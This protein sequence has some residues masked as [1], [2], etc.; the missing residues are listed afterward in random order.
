[1]VKK[2]TL[3]VITF[4]LMNIF[5]VSFISAPFGYNNREFVDFTINTFT[6]NLT[7]LSELQDVDVTGVNNNDVLT[8]DS[9]SGLWEDQP[10]SAVGDTNE[11]TR[12]NALILTNC[13][14]TDKVIGVQSNGTVSCDTDLNTGGGVLSGDDVYLYNDSTTMSFNTTLA[15]TNLSVNS[16]NF[17]DNYNTT[18]TT[19]LEN[20]GG[21]L[22]IIDS[23]IE[24]LVISVLGNFF[25]QDL[26]ESSSVKFNDVNATGLYYG[27]GSQ[28]TG[29]TLT[30]TDPQWT[31]NQSLY[32]NTTDI[33]GFSYYNLTRINTTQ[34][35]S[36]ANLTLNETWMNLVSAPFLDNIQNPTGDVGFN[37]GNQEIDFTFAVPSNDAFEIEG[38][39]AFAGELLHVHQHI[40]NPTSTNL[41]GLHAEDSDVLGL[42]I[43]TTN[44]IAIRVLLGN[45]SLD[46]GGLYATDWTN[47]SITEAQISNLVHTGNSSWNET[48][49]NTLYSTITEPL[50]TANS[51]LYP[52]NIS[53]NSSQFTTLANITINETWLN[54]LTSGDNASWNET[55]AGTQFYDI[56]DNVLSY[57]NTT[58]ATFN[59]TF[60]D[61]LYYD[62]DANTHTYWNDT[63]ASFNQTFGDG[64]YLQSFTETDPHWT[65]NQTLYPLNI[66]F[67]SS[68]FT[69]L[70]NITI[71]ETWITSLAIGDN[72]SWNETFATSLYSLITEPLW[73]A[74]FTLYP[75]NI[76]FNSSQFTT[77]LNITI[78]ET[79]LSSIATGDNA[80][81]NETLA[82]TLYILQGNEGNLNVNSSDFWDDLD[83]FNST[84]MEDSGGFL[85]IL[86][87]WLS[88]FI[89]SVINGFFDQDLNKTSNVTH[90]NIT[91][92]F[93]FGD[94]SQLQNLPSGTEPLWTANS[95]IYPLNISFNSSQ[96]TTLANITINETWLNTLT[97]GDNASWNET[98]ANTLY[99]DIDNNVL[100]YW[101]S[102]FALFNKT[103]ADTLYYDID[104]NVLGYYNSTDFSISDYVPYT[105]ATSNL[106]LGA[107]NFSVDSSVLFVNANDNFV[108]IGTTTPTQLLDIAGSMNH[109]VDGTTRYFA[110]GC[111]EIAN[112]TGLFWVC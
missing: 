6:G 11:T 33:E 42:F 15:G 54:T 94:G 9:G 31:G 98:F 112:S 85:N 37:F 66:S 109:S 1:M 104:D 99:Y 96:F 46:D 82:N 22:H 13:S 18:N 10:A 71:N 74:N 65:G 48:F 34:F 2:K 70:A 64:R 27:N 8:Y 24:G 77:T 87:S 102:T 78:N 83:T 80:S 35:I 67:N 3:V 88:G 21:L 36:L 47:V 26:N 25:D 32:Y 84:Q 17:W 75:L 111:S 4:I 50:W 45:I 16:S 106:V 40:G 23:F 89:V 41:V 56:D 20:Q 51:T 105:G 62:I 73:S 81:W 5:L 14:G 28:L 39:G 19:Q 7:N 59:K 53:F 30:E 52:L 60:A 79:W 68:Q 91:A 72:A 49:A 101:N 58:F 93:Y 103:Y 100:S 108:G 95:T 76:S 92:D 107:N 69:T 110:N 38:T 43:N 86:P 12:F 90:S 29:L 55:F 61:T 63:F 97:S 57:W 44:Q